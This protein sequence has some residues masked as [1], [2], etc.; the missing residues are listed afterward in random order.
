MVPRDIN[1][2]TEYLK[3]VTKFM[4]L[5]Y[6]AEQATQ[7]RTSD[8]SPLKKSNQGPP[9]SRKKQKTRAPFGGTQKKNMC[10]KATCQDKPPHEWVNC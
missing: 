9:S 5:M 2:S 8:G 7:K 3:S 6:K 4:K 10:T 1:N